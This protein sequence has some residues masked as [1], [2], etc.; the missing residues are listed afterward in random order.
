MSAIANYLK[1][2]AEELENEI[3][4]QQRKINSAKETIALLKKLQVAASVST[5]TTQKPKPQPV[6]PTSTQAIPKPVQQNAEGM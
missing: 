5:S 6:Q 3:N 1:M 2:T 4:K